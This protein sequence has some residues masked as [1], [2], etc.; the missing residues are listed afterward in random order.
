VVRMAYYLVC[1]AVLVIGMCIFR[2]YICISSPAKL[3]I[4]HSTD[5]PCIFSAYGVGARVNSAMFTGEQPDFSNV[6][7][8][9]ILVQPIADS[10]ETYLVDV[11][12]GSASLARP[13]VL[14]DTAEVMGA[15]PPEKHRLTRR[16]HP[17]SSLGE[18]LTS[19]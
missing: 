11:G 16:P 9:V 18:C 8:L 4:L 15:A 2:S 13:I 5:K 12:F 6:A 10:N 3:K 19:P 7:H 14:S 17:T 1:F